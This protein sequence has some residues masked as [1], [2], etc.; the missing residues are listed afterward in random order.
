VIAF[1]HTRDELTQGAHIVW[2]H[3]R[4]RLVEH[5]ADGVDVG[6]TVDLPRRA[7]LLGSHVARRAD[8]GVSRR[9][10]AVDIARIREVRDAEVEDANPFFAARIALYEEIARLEVAMDDPEIV[11]GDQSRARRNQ[12]PRDPLERDGTARDHRRERLTSEQLHQYIGRAVLELACIDRLHDGGT[13]HDRRHARFAY[14]T[15]AVLWIVPQLPMKNLHRPLVLCGRVRDAVDAARGAFAEQRFDA[16][17]A[18]EHT[19][20]PGI[21][22]RH[23]LPEHRACGLPV[24][25]LLAM[26]GTRTQREERERPTVVRVRVDVLRGPDAGTRFEAEHDVPLSIGSAEGNSLVLR[27][28]KVSRF[29]LELIREDDGVRV[30]DLGSMNGTW[31]N[32]V[33]IER[34]VL[35]PGTE[36]RLGDT[37]IA[38]RDGAITLAE[39]PEPAE[40]LPGVVAASAQSRR[41]AHQIRNLAPSTVTV[42]LRGETGT[43]KEVAARALH[44]LSMRSRRPFVVVDCGSVP[45]MLIESEL[46]G[47]ERGAFTG[48]DRK[49]AGA[50]ERANGGT[51]FLDEIG[52]LPLSVQPALLAPLERRRFRRVGGDS[53]IEVD[54]RVVA[55]THR[56]LRSSVNGGTFRADLY[57]RLA[58]AKLELP[59]LRERTEDIAPLIRHFV[60]EITGAAD[61]GPFD[62]ATIAELTRHPWSGNVRE[63]RNVVEAA[64]AFGEVRVDGVSQPPTVGVSDAKNAFSDEL[65][66]YRDARAVAL[67]TFERSYFR[68]LVARCGKNASLAARVAKMDR[69]HLAGLL[70]KHGLR[71]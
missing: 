54:V 20:D 40:P 14:E 50:F 32:S 55:A 2:P 33:S 1:V 18:H 45:A 62:D 12:E 17:L 58:V 3:T 41:L 63:L 7:E 9:E 51:V 23:P 65:P 64:I 68:S 38:V 49:R 22:L 60:R 29:H 66:S 26:D 70:R 5:D 10:R 52:E 19:T 35:C 13:L 31:L 11:R 27:D 57:Y 16:E 47:H 15:S 28:P 4:E 25:C 37:T 34:A 24:Q 36:L 43:G 46:F 42:L 67:D 56:D 6:A 8:R 69:T 30:Q 71:D 59:P 21:V 44:D 61:L 48:A 53:E 39:E